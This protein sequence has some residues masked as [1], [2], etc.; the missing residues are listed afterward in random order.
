M[1]AQFLEADLIDALTLSVVPMTLGTGL[2]LFGGSLGSDKRW[3]L[4]GTQSWPTGLAQ[5][6]YR[7]NRSQTQPTY[8][9]R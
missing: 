9:V 1:I 8:G 6:R 5:L 7:R 4:E 3:A 2:R